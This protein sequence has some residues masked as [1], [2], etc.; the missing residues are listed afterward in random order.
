MP[1][2]VDDPRW[3]ALNFDALRASLD[4]PRANDGRIRV[5]SFAELPPDAPRPKAPVRIRWSLVCMGYQ[6]EPAT[7]WSAGTRNLGEEARQDRVFEESLFWGVT[8]TIHCFY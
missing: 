7:A 2:R 8:R 3:V 4:S 1:T 6:P 5:P